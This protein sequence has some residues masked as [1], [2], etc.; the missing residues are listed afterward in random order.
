MIVGGR[1]PEL[2]KPL[3][4]PNNLQLLHLECHKERTK[5]QWE[6]L[7]LYREERDKLLKGWKI[8]EL[9]HQE[10]DWVTVNVYI[11]LYEAG[12]LSSLRLDSPENKR[13]KGLYNIAK[14]VKKSRLSQVEVK[15]KSRMSGSRIS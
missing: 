11:N 3:R 13:I 2:T 9:G 1:V 5:S 8:K 6:F 4:H 10:L 7:K 15:E 14:R 12:K